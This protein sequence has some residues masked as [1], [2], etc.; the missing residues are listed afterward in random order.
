[1]PGGIDVVKV[2]FYIDRESGEPHIARHDVSEH[3]AC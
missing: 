1:L 2:R 3:E